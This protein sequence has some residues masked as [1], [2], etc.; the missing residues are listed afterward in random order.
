MGVTVALA[1]V[2]GAPGAG[3][4]DGTFG[5]VAARPARYI[6]RY[7]PGAAG[8]ALLTADPFKCCATMWAPFCVLGGVGPSKADS[9]PGAVGMISSVM[10]SVSAPL[11]LTSIGSCW[12]AVI[13][14]GI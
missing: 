14:T 6:T 3:L 1:R 11:T 13:S 5:S 10:G 8:L 2:A 7:S 9:T 4:P 12:G